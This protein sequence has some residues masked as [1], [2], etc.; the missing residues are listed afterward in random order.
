MRVGSVLSI[1]WKFAFQ[2][3]RK[4]I[5]IKESYSII[6]PIYVALY[7]FLEWL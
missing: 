2:N 4:F 1:K 7:M 6:I 3:E 5:I